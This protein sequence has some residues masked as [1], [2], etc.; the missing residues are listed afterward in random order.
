[1]GRCSPS[2]PAPRIV[3]T[4]PV[5][6]IQISPDALTQ[7]TATTCGDVF[8]ELPIKVRHSALSSALLLELQDECGSNPYGAKYSPLE[9]NTN[10]FLEKQLQLL[11]E[12][13]EDLQQESGKLTHYERS[14]QRQK[15]AQSQYLSRKKLE[16]VAR[17]ARGEEPTLEDDTN[18]NPLFKPIPKPSRLESLLVTNQMSA[19]CEQINRFSGQSFANLFLVQSLNAS[20]R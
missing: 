7:S 16:A 17:A 8:L 18:S 4:C 11:I 15:L 9:L 10:S 20:Q 5:P 3:H 13:I 12:C 1:M 19:Y 14:V 6:R 2:A